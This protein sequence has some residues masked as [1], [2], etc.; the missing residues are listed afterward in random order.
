MEAYVTSR[1]PI[2]L[3]GT[4]FP[5]G[6]DVP[7]ASAY[8]P[9]GG[10][11]FRDQTTLAGVHLPRFGLQSRD[12]TT[13]TTDTS[14]PRNSRQHTLTTDLQPPQGSQ[15]SR[16]GSISPGSSLPR[17]RQSGDDDTLP[18]GVPLARWGWQSGDTTPSPTGSLTRP[19]LPVHHVQTEVEALDIISIG[20]SLSREE[21]ASGPRAEPYIPPPDYEGRW[22]EG[23]AGTLE[24]GFS[25]VSFFG[26]DL[27]ES[28]RGLQTLPRPPVGG[29]LRLTQPFDE[30]LQ[31]D[32]P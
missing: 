10:R 23:A 12:D 26:D 22:A 9:Q 7:A 20:R 18:V 2:V 17:S 3:A 13:M 28:S 6:D 1:D 32:T 11:A 21:S 25:E 29:V 31:N 24:D 14:L 8:L 15:Y 27:E 4:D 19:S 30:D 5:P 16:E